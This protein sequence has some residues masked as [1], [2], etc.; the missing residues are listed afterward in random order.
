MDHLNA[1]LALPNTFHLECII[2]NNDLFTI[3]IRSQAKEARC[4]TCHCVSNSVHSHYWRYLQDLP[5]SQWPIQLQLRVVRFR[6]CNPSCVRRTFVEDITAYVPRY[7][8][9]TKR[10]AQLLAHVGFEFGG[11]AGA[12]VAHL[13]RLSASRSTLLRLVRRSQLPPPEP[14]EVL[15][16]DDWAFCRG[17]HYGTILVDLERRCVVDLLPDAEATSLTAWLQAHPQVRIISRDRDSTYAEG[18]S[19]GAPTA[20]QIA[21]R[22]HLFKNLW[23]ALVLAYTQHITALRQ[24][25]VAPSPAP[26]Q[27][28]EPLPAVRRSNR[29]PAPPTP[30]EQ[31]RAARRQYWEAIF[32]QV[33][34]LRTQ[35][36]SK[37]AIAK[38]LGVSLSLVKK[39]CRLE[40]LP[41]KRSPKFKPLLIAPYLDTLRTRL[42]AGPVST[43][44][45]LEE[46]QAQGFRGSRSTVY[47]AV[48]QL[49]QE[50]HPPSP[51][52]APKPEPVPTLRVTPQQLASW[53]FVPNLSELKQELFQKALALHPII[54]LATRLAQDFIMFVRQQKPL[55]LVPWIEAVQFTEVGALKQ[56]AQG[57]LRDFEAVYAA[58]CQP[59]SNGQVEGQVNRLKFIKRQ[60][61]GRANFDLLRLR[62]LYSGTLCT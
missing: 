43:A 8:R 17:E 28:N 20:L 57:L 35:G 54:E 47:K 55:H 44:T 46:L 11:Q 7:S 33:H 2:R 52:L 1:I 19:Q 6:C 21:D 41:K 42:L 61:Y 9:R 32:A 51:L 62:V 27:L 30:L 53:V 56:F 39:Y 13:Y 45:L 5:L 25:T 3:V 15:G 60:M 26:I 40:T 36:I 23:D 58:C 16:V 50:L 48:V 31:A 22:W 37:P 29:P 24:L 10:A 18:A 4:P 12:R 49:R 59:W 34:D 38:Q 14:V